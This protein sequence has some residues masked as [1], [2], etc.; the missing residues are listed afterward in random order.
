MESQVVFFCVRL[1]LLSIVCMRLVPVVARVGGEFLFIAGGT[2]LY[3]EYT[4]IC[5]AILLLIDVWV[6]SS[7]DYSNLPYPQFCLSWFQL[8]GINP[9]PEADVPPSD[10]GSE[11]HQ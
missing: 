4:T 8:R 11:T 9:S 10:I 2:P 3:K 5:L 1:L 7:P 6:V